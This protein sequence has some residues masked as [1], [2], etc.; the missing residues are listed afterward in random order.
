MTWVPTK[1]LPDEDQGT[2]H[3]FAFSFQNNL[4]RMTQFQPHF[5]AIGNAVQYRCWATCLRSNV[6]LFVQ[7][8]FDHK[9]PGSR[10][11]HL[12]QYVEYYVLTQPCMPNTLLQAAGLCFPHK[13][14]NKWVFIW[15]HINQQQ[16]DLSTRIYFFLVLKIGSFLTYHNLVTVYISSA[17]PNSSL[18][19]ASLSASH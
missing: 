17:S 8:Q 5:K 19:S 16:T 7:P 12:L 15:R 18:H 3:F 1:Y 4:R 10:V 6:W 2:S 11:H 9:L 14:K 13:G